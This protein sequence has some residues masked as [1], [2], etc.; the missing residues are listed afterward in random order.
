MT[1]LLE[2]AGLKV[3]FPMRGGSITVV[4]D[5]SFT[6]DESDAIVVLGESGAGKSVLAQ[7]L[8]GLLP[9]PGEITAGEIIFDGQNLTALNNT[10]MR[11][12]RGGEIG[13][14]F[15]NPGAALSPLQTVGRQ[16]TDVA[17]LHLRLSKTQGEKAALELLSAV[18]FRKPG[19]IASAFP[20]ELSGGMQQRAALAVA[21]AGEPRLLIADEPTA[22]LDA[23]LREEILGLLSRLKKELG[24][25]LILIT[26]DL[27]V[28]SRIADRILLLYAGQIVEEAPATAF[29][30]HPRHPYGQA[31]MSCR[32]TPSGEKSGLPSSIAGEVPDFRD[33]PDGCRFHPRCSMIL[34]ECRSEMPEAI[35]LGAHQHVACHLEKS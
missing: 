5:A 25:A 35:G 7:A 8:I 23:P 27:R 13:F 29:L 22:A 34:P 31:L 16:I 14:L 33:L 15:Q 4:D 30:N 12:V 3:Q 18:E 24:L 17:R 32:P 19:E 20:H 28:A 6:M 11:Q 9:S 21:L 1:T 10:E 26:H 2:V